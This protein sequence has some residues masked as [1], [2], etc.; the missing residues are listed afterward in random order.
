MVGQPLSNEAAG[1]WQAARRAA[2][3]MSNLEVHGF[4]KHARVGDFLSEAAVFVHT[5]GREGFP[6]T[7]LE[8]W[9]HGIPTVT[10]VDPGGTIE[11]HKIGKVVTSFEGLTDAVARMMAAPHERR[12]IGARA[13]R[14]VEEHHGSE[15]SYEP[16]AALLDRVIRDRDRGDLRGQ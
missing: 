10:A 3:A 14:Y 4:V 8:A 1:S 7:L 13:R 5:S 6:M 9:S 16:L 12:A 15:R 11:R 2:V